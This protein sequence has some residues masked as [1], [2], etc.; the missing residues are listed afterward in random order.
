MEGICVV[1]VV[2]SALE[3]ILVLSVVD[4]RVVV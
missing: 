4:S 3:G 2:V 1:V